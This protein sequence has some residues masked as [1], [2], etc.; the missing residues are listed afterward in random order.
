MTATQ[1]TARTTTTRTA[2]LAY[3]V[4]PRRMEAGPEVH[5]HG[6][7][8]ILRRRC[9]SQLPKP[10]RR[11]RGEAGGPERGRTPAPLP[12]LRR[13]CRP[14]PALRH[15]A[16]YCATGSSGCSV[17]QPA[18]TPPQRRCAR[19]SPP[20]GGHVGAGATCVMLPRATA[21]PGRS[22]EGSD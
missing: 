12:R 10:P 11:L 14:R 15:L 9:P 22:P 18:R 2:V 1:D 3:T 6:Y 20:R 5:Q 4:M 16:R 21:M 19:A 13:L 7:P 8:R 17:L